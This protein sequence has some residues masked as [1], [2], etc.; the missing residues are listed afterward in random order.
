MSLKW[1]GQSLFLGVL[2][3]G[4]VA[5]TPAFAQDN[6]E[7]INR[8]SVAE[9]VDHA[10]GFNQYWSEI[11]IVDDAKWVFGIEH[12]EKRVEGRTHRFERLYA[13]LMK[14]QSEDHEILRTQDIPSPFNT[15]L[16]NLQ[17][18]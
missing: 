8:P 4:A 15:S 13:D 1:A 18:K 7:P 10:T 9:Q 12:G 3:V 2:A 16:S 11:A 6:N 17:N 5:S 14:Q